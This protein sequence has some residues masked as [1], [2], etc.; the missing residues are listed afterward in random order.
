MRRTYDNPQLG[1]TLVHSA[2]AILTLSS[3]T[4]VLPLAL[5]SQYA[6]CP[7]GLRRRTSSEEGFLHV[8]LEVLTFGGF[9]E[10]FRLIYH[11][12]HCEF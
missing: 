5:L 10:G 11:S 4:Q 6:L 3:I 1:L 9:E 12:L 8:L 2:R 7:L